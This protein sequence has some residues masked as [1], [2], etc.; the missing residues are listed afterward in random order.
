MAIASADM[1]ASVAV[2]IPARRMEPGL[3]PLV[4]ALSRTGFGAIVV[5]SDGIS[6]DEQRAFD[7]LSEIS[8]VHLLRH[9]VN[10]GKGR[11]L[12]TGINFVLTELTGLAVLVTAD[13]D[14]QHAVDDIIRVAQAALQR[15]R[16]VVLGCRRFTKD[17]PARSRFG[18]TLTRLVFSFFSGREV[19][20]TQTGLR[21]FP[22]ALLPEL[23]AL[24]GD[25]YEY[26]MTVLAHLSRIGAELIEVPIATIYIDDNRSSHFNPVRDSM[27]IYFVLVRFY[28]SSLVS[29]GLDLA[30]FT[31]TFW[32]SRNIL[33]AVLVGRASSL[34]NFVLNR[35]LVFRSQRSVKE[36]LGRYYA[37]AA[38]L[39]AISYGAILGCSS[40]LGWNI[41][42]V[43]ISVE[44][45][46]SL[47]SFSVQRTFVFAPGML[48]EG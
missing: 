12:K 5:V 2:L 42:I 45:A 29:A 30:F 26:E 38:V 9:A 23:L 13:A 27:R 28:A 48:E 40:W 46:L 31:L 14:G 25:R 18:N 3:A 44:T 7:A 17:V 37:L 35:S 24:P 47:I 1:I 33:L 43:K 10:L 41:V 39:A 8:H 11:A 4:E 6:N 19:S 20:D 16:G 21:S 32:M 36:A 34:V 22:I 15:P